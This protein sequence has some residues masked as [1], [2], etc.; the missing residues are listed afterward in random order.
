[1]KNFVTKI[2]IIWYNLKKM[3]G[4]EM[5]LDV[6]TLSNIERICIKYN[7]GKGQPVKVNVVLNHIDDKHCFLS[8]NLLTNFSKPRW[9][10]PVEVF[11]YTSSGVYQGKAKIRAVNILLKKI[12][13]KIDIPKTWEYSQF[14][15]SNRKKCQFPA[16]ITFT[17]DTI[18]EASIKEINLAGFAIQTNQIFTT[19]QKKFPSTC[20]IRMKIDEENIETLTQSIMYVREKDMKDEEYYETIHLACFKFLNI[21][22]KNLA[23]LKKY[24]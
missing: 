13:Y 12:N 3:E 22:D 8:T 15:K 9:W 23:I 10:A 6:F 5:T 20:E 21:S 2:N 4:N 1:M 7:D 19:I 16:K 11:V 14:R 17:D 24:I 18:I